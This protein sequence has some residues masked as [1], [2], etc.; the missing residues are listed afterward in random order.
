[1][2]KRISSWLIVLVLW[3]GPSAFAQ[4]G[5]SLSTEELEVNLESSS[6]AERIEIL[7][8]LADKLRYQDANKALSF[9]EESFDLAKVI[10]SDSL[11]AESMFRMGQ[12]ELIRGNSL[13]ALNYLFDARPLFVDLGLKGRESRVLQ[14]IGSTYIENGQFDEASKT[15]FKSLELTQEIND[16]KGEV[17]NLNALGVIHV[18]LGD[19]RVAQ[20]FLHDAIHK[21]R[22]IGDWYNETISLSEAATLEEKFNNVEKALEYYEKVLAIF[23]E[24]GVSHAVPM[25]IYNMANLY[26]DRNRLEESVELA[27]EG[28]NFAD[29]LGNN[30]LVVNG[31]RT[32]AAIYSEMGDYDLAI[33]VLEGAHEQ[34]QLVGHESVKYPFLND[35][36]SYYFS[37]GNYQKA[38]STALESKNDAVDEGKW[39]YAKEALEVLI[40]SEVS[41]DKF[42]S[43]L[44]HQGELIA[45]KDSILNEERARN[46]LEFDIRYQVSQKE[47]EIAILEAQNEQK[48]TMQAALIGGFVLVLVIVLLV[49]RSQRLKI[50]RGQADLE[51]QKLRRKELEHDL[52]FKNKQLTTQSLNMVQKNEIMV[53][54]KEKVEN[55]KQAGGSREL[56]NLSNLVDYSFTLD[57]DWK[58]F[59]MHFEEV[60]SSFYHVLKDRYGDLTPNEMRLSALV[61]LNLSIKEMAAILGISPDSVKTAR[62]RLRKKLGLNTEDNLTEFM[63]KIERESLQVS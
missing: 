27:K 1:M 45:V 29:S 33:E 8:K 36:A 49:V 50:Q 44:V 28:I 41:S 62:Y 10:K 40:E 59:R 7:I 17:F 32:L 55:L 19:Y 43:A 35:L 47:N 24:K 34:A 11:I 38:I 22:E 25:I 60:H 18:N 39:V 56:N 20:R 61:K 3:I 4:H 63:L 42:S 52:E 51:I 16:E 37:S 6:G 12:V 46:I 5:G 58:Q 54:M 53:E 2:A 26:K 23:E 21:A 48:S 31:I 57:N 13:T 30:Y 9:A 14:V 15:Y